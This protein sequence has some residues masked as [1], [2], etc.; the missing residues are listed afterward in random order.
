MSAKNPAEYVSR[1]VWLLVRERLA[2]G[3]PHDFIA[4]EVGLSTGTIAGIA[5]ERIRPSRIVVEEDDPL[6]EEMLTAKRCPGCGALVF[7]W[8]C[9]ACQMAAAA[10]LPVKKAKK[11][12]AVKRI[13]GRA[14]K[15]KLRRQSALRKAG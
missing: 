3:L 15:S 4:L 2:D 6:R 9:L 14:L 8:P 12:R 11:P 13:G 10:K 1:R 5:A 7:T